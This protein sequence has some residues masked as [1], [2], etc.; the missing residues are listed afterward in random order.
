MCTDL[1][2]A[3]HRDAK[4]KCDKQARE[5]RFA[6]N[7]ADGGEWLARLPRVCDRLA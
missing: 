7:G 5:R 3:R 4:Q 6:G 2:P 1:A